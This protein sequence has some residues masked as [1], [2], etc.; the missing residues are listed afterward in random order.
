MEHSSHAHPLPHRQSTPSHDPLLPYVSGTIASSAPNTLTS[1]SPSDRLSRQARRLQLRNAGFR[2]TTIPTRRISPLFGA[3]PVGI[4]SFTRTTYNENSTLSSEKRSA[5]SENIPPRPVNILQEIHKSARKKRASPRPG[6]HSIFQDSTAQAPADESSEVSSYDG[7]SYNCS[8]SATSPSP[9]MP[10]LREVSGN[11]RNP[12]VTSPLAKQAK[13]RKVSRLNRRSTSFDATQHIEYLERE[14]ALAN[15][16]NDP[17]SS[18]AARKRRSTKMRALAV[19][20]SNLREE[21][22]EWHNKYDA[23]VED[24]VQKR[25]E[26]EATMKE[27]LEAWEFESGMKDARIGELE[28][29]LECMKIQARDSEGFEE[30]NKDLEKRI[31]VLTNLLVQSPVRTSG[32]SAAT[33]PTKLEPT[34]RTSM[35]RSGLSKVPISPGG[36]RLSLATVSE[37]EFWQSQ[38]FASDSGRSDALDDVDQLCASA[39]HILPPNYE[40]ALRSADTMEQPRRDGPL[41]P[42]S[43][44]SASMRSLPSSSS[45]PTSFLSTSSFGGVPW[46]FPVLPESE[47]ELNTANKKRRMRRFASGSKSLKP[48]VLPTATNIPSLPASAPVYPL[49]G[50]NA[51]HNLSAISLDPTTSFLSR[52]PSTPPIQTPTQPQHRPSPAGAYDQALKTLEGRFQDLDLSHPACPILT[53]SSGDVSAP[54]PASDETEIKSDAGP[55]LRPRSLQKELEEAENAQTGP[56]ISPDIH[57]GPFE[58]G[59]IP[60]S[61]DG[62]PEVGQ[63]FIGIEAPSSQCS[64]EDVDKR[65]CLQPQLYDIAPMSGSHLVPSAAIPIIPTKAS[66]SMA[67]TSQVAHGIFS[68]LTNV[69]R[70]TKQDPVKLAQRVLSNAWSLNSSRLLGGVGWWLL[71]L[72]YHRRK[73]KQG[74]SAD[75]VVADENIDQRIRERRLLLQL[76]DEKMADQVGRRDRQEYCA[77]AC[78]ARTAE[79]HYGDSGGMGLS[80]PDVRDGSNAI[81]GFMPGATAPGNPRRITC[82]DCIE[83]SSRRTLRLWVHFSLTI[84]LAVGMALRHGPAVLLAELPGRPTLASGPGNNQFAVGEPPDSRGDGQARTTAG[85]GARDDGEKEKKGMTGYRTAESGYG[86]IV[87]TETL[88]PA[89]FENGSG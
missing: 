85:Y 32:P 80:P 71:G 83:P 5:Y 30:A 40:E 28:W 63:I 60:L 74:D 67:L 25:L 41:G 4:E 49:I 56:A 52:L 86:R 54:V 10:K 19:E 82:H 27:R 12:P 65:Q 81:A 70:R 73:R 26:F 43:R 23:R 66:P 62:S 42:R 79:H 34:K 48:L 14:L 59:L 76:M 24:E 75:V 16:K 88:G 11:Q 8:P 37:D 68:R 89:D 69:V 15:A 78:Q 45:R 87:F 3:C 39:E 35:P 18:S 9:S 29:E 77:E 38:S 47:V 13:D 6:L 17:D 55:R 21:L 51:E 53:T 50:C 33:S 1:P 2:A 31:D 61:R 72:V 22:A 7:A 46:G 84:V 20:N 64:S 44:A 36:V 57:D 58:E